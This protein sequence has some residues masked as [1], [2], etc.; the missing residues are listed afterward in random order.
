MCE[1]IDEF[2]SPVLSNCKIVEDR[3]KPPAIHC[4]I[5]GSHNLILANPKM[6]QKGAHD[7]PPSDIAVK[8]AREWAVLRICKKP[9]STKYR[10]DFNLEE[11]FEFSVRVDDYTK[12]PVA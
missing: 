5:E 4:L 7:M 2:N 9:D 6:L 1:L 8:I 11:G 3:P 12:E 10:L